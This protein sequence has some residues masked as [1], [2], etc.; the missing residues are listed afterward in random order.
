MTARDIQ[1]RLVANSYR[2]N[3]ALCNYTP[4]GWFECDVFEVT[5]AGYMVEYEIKLSR[6]DFAADAKKAKERWEINHTSGRAAWEKKVEPTKWEQLAANQQAGPSRFWFVIPCGVDIRDAEV[7]EWAGFIKAEMPG[8]SWRRIQMHVQR[9]APLLH[10]VKVA[11][12]ILEH[13][14]SVCYW[15]MHKLFLKT[16]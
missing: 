15:R 11:P 6:S 3:F 4:R 5:K 1:R 2:H 16:T 8:E 7:P 9:P 14:Q 10:R 12:S 13:A